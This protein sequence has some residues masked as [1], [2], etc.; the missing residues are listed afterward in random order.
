MYYYDRSV[1]MFVT[2]TECKMFRFDSV[3]RWFI[4]FPLTFYQQPMH[5]IQ[6]YFICRQPIVYIFR[7]SKVKAQWCSNFMLMSDWLVLCYVFLFAKTNIKD[8]GL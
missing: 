3:C 1:N 7:K 6:E 2:I 8:F 4:V 5:S